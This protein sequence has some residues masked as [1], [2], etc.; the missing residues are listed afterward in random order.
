M[1][2]ARLH[3]K[4][5]MRGGPR[6]MRRQRL[7]RF[8]SPEDELAADGTKLLERVVL[9][10]TSAGA[11]VKCFAASA[12]PAPELDGPV[13]L[14]QDPGLV[15]APKRAQYGNQALTTHRALGGSPDGAAL[16][17]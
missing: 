5:G 6:G 2:A 13:R 15:R 10:A 1:P 17:P 14:S 11:P 4:P 9:R 8:L 16:A 7:G 3:R 12:G